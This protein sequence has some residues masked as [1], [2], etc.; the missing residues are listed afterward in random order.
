MTNK[1]TKGKIMILPV[2]GGEWTQ[3]DDKF[4]NKYYCRLIERST[5]NVL[6]I[7]SAWDSKQEKVRVVEITIGS[8]GYLISPEDISGFS[9]PEAF[10]K[11][12]FEKIRC[13]PDVRVY[14]KENLG[15][16]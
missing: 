14:S 6:E 9:S 16:K 2:F 7:M 3:I 11:W 15:F 5:R 10:F 8:G 1:D 13:L 12:W 4:G